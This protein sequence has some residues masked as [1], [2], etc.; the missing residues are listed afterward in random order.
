[1]NDGEDSGVVRELQHRVDARH[2]T[3]LLLMISSDSIVLIQI[4]HWVDA[5][6]ITSLLLLT[7]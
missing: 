3:T 2:L 6:H 5:G 7:S 1:M 4:Q